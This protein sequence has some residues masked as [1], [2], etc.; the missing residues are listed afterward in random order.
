MVV[1]DDAEPDLLEGRARAK[2]APEGEDV[3]LP[4][5]DLGVLEERVD[6]LEGV[7]LVGHVLDVVVRRAEPD[8]G[9]RAPARRPGGRRGERDV[10]VHLGHVRREGLRG[11]RL[12]PAAGVGLQHLR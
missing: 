2:G 12:G 9:E 5:L 8:V 3:L 4:A 7:D 6:G 1:L 10:G 11:G